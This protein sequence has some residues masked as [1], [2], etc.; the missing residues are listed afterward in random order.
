MTRLKER[1]DRL[2]MFY[3]LEAH[4]QGKLANEV[5]IIFEGRQWT[6]QETYQSVL[7]YGTWLRQKYDVKPK[8]IVA[9]DFMNSEKFIF[10]WFGL[11]S[12]GAKPAFINYNLTGKALAHCVRVSTTKLAL[13]DYQVQ[14]CVTDDVRKELPA[15]EWVIFTPE[16]E[17]EAAATEAVR[18]PDWTRSE[19]KSQNMAKLVFT[20]G[21]TG[22]PKPAIVS[23]TKT[24][25]G[26]ILMPNWASIARPDV[27]YT[28]RLFPPSI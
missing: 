22:L 11:W 23:W 18:A 9:M 1:W 5:F 7:K 26:S 21:T 27:Y 8:Q 12:I 4:A 20:S 25:V 14:E 16:L 24:N 17:A 13:I 28:V 19:D 15:V 6:Y 2:N 10:V 3:T